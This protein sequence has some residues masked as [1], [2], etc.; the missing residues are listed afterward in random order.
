MN[1]NLQNNEFENEKIK[2]LVDKIEINKKDINIF[3]QNKSIIKYVRTFFKKISVNS[4]IKLIKL[5]LDNN[6][7]IFVKQISKSKTF[8]RENQIRLAKIKINDSNEWIIE[9]TTQQNIKEYIYNVI[10]K[11]KIE[12]EYNDDNTNIEINENHLYRDFRRFICEENGELSISFDFDKTKLQT[13]SIKNIDTLQRTNIQIVSRGVKFDFPIK[14]YYVC[15]RCGHEIE[16]DAYIMSSTN[17]RYKCE[18]LI[19]GETK[20]KVCGQTLTP[21]TEISR[22]KECYFYEINYE[23]EEGEKMTANSICFD[24][25]DPGFYNCVL[26]KINNPNKTEIFHIVNVKDIDE[27]K[28]E[29]PQ[30][31]EDENYLFTLQ[32]TIDEYI[33]KRI[34]LKIAG[35]QIIKVSL[36]IQKIISLLGEKLIGNIQIVGD[37]STGKSML[38]KYYSTVLD[39]SLFISTNGLSVSIPALRGTKHSVTLMG[40]EQ[41]IISVGML[42]TYNNIHIDEAGENK[43]LVQ[44]LKTFALEDTYSYNKAGSTGATYV[45]RSHINLSENVDHQHLQQYTRTI[46][47]KYNDPSYV[48]ETILKE[49][50]TENWNETWDLHLP[51]NEYSNIRLRQV[52]E[53]V[54]SEYYKNKIFWIDGY[55]YALHERFPFYF[56]LVHGEK[57]NEEI[58]NAVKFNLQQKNTIKDNVNLIKVL[59]NDM[60][61]MLLK[62][63]KKYKDIPEDVETFYKVDEILD[64]YNVE[65]DYRMKTFYYT[66]VKISRIV[67]RREK[68]NEQDFNI[69][70]LLLERTNRRCSIN[71]ISSTEIKGITNTKN[72]TINN[73][74]K[75]V[76]QN[77]NSMF[78]IGVDDFD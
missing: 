30:K 51:L 4:S 5:I 18:G 46:R 43:E 29:V 42:G 68:A 52:I 12:F 21:D 40:K 19:I 75:E 33:E 65:R 44:N 8:I 6:E 16:K 31:I 41:S 15:E 47:K 10:K 56:Y 22:V 26:Y 1:N 9:T 73:I 25:L 32:K 27:N 48:T 20:P 53:D 70:K 35:L 77:T 78:G 74:E 36:I 63:I 45:R 64:E 61:K 62:V 39:N 69:L 2:E 11:H 55:D 14:Y 50:E 66:I 71:D 17:T 76:K 23:T 49:E 38:L 34:N 28:L 24:Q 60:F 58:E 67:N 3:S 59:K 54:R 37:R 57:N 7:V 72:N 13:K